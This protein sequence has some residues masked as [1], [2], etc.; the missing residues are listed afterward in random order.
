MGTVEVDC[1]ANSADTGI[2]M[3]WRADEPA[4][5]Q[6]LSSTTI[7]MTDARSTA[8]LTLPPGATVTRAFLYWGA[9]R[10]SSVA[11]L[12]AT[13]QRPGVDQAPINV[14]AIQ[15][16]VPT[17]SVYQSVA[18][19]TT[20]VQERGSGPYRVGGVD[21]FP[22]SGVNSDTAYAGWWMAVF[23]EKI[24]EP[25]RNLALFDGLDIVAAPSAGNPTPTV[26][27]TLS[28]F[29]VPPAASF[30][31]LGVIAYEGDGAIAQDSFRFNGVQISDAL[32][33]ADNFFNGTRSYLGMPVSVPGDLPQLTGGPLS[34]SSIDMDVID[35]TAHLAPLQTSAVIEA[36]G[37]GDVIYLAGYTT[38]IVT[39][40]PD[41]TTS[42]K[43]VQDLNG[44]GLLPG[45]ILE[46]TVAIENSGDDASI[47]TVLTDAL[48]PGVTYVPGSLAITSG[49]NAGA[50]TDAAGDDQGDYAAGTRTLTVRLGT[51][52]GA[53]AGG[54][55]PVGA[56]STVTFRVTVDAGT[57]G[58]IE[59]QAVISAGGQQG[60]P[61]TN[62][63]T[64]GNGP[65]G[66]HPPTTVVVDLCSTDAQCAAP[67]P[68][69]NTAPTPNECVA[70]VTDLH[71]PPTAPT[72]EA[73]THTC[74][75][76]P[77]GAE[78][79]DGL[80]NDCDGEVDDG[81]S[82]VDTD[83]DGLGDDLE[84]TIGTDPN[85][86]DSD[87]DGVPDGQ[88]PG[89]D[90]DSDGDGLI[91]AL[92][93]D[94]DN[95]GL[96][97]GTEMGL[98][99]ANP[100]TDAGAMSCVADGDQ[101][102]TLTDPLD[103]DTDDGGVEDGDEDRDHDGV[104]DADET[105]PTAGNGADDVLNDDADGDGLSGI[106]ELS[107]G[108]DPNDADSDDDGVPDGLE[109]GLGEDTDNDGLIGA[110]DPDSDNDG[111][112][113]GTEMG[114]DC[115]NPDTDPSVMSCIADA[116]GGATTTDPL[117]PDT[118]GGSVSDGDEDANHDG[119]VNDGERD[120]NDP[121]D[122]VTPEIPCTQDSACGGPNSGIVCDTASGNCGPG[123][124]GA[125]GNGCPEGQECSSSDAT[126]GT[127]R[128][129]VPGVEE[130]DGMYPEGNGLLC[131]ARPGPAGGGGGALVVAMAGL[132][133]LALRRRRREP[134]A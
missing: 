123:C 63:P 19:I 53:T 38:S 3:V 22:L 14:T 112:F 96:F 116:D 49:A 36:Q 100:A 86:A 18:D 62:T 72:C 127:C 5:G 78:V 131:A 11:D 21:I 59:N 13:I 42:T 71:C 109:P 110:L 85:D 120:P 58:S 91:G 15:S 20:I 54:V 50:K 83:G 73:A 28:G 95:D 129:P 25:L 61:V 134:R 51:G 126:A 60:A 102:A 27:T 6:A 45:D 79:C 48:P 7:A 122:D 97:D 80:D 47:N 12:T 23:Y 115:T 88:E 128:T 111:L 34:M 32:N 16:F 66:G 68:H 74:I 94:S 84:L 64:D 40:A 119:Q 117:D 118:D 37:A 39:F 76:V 31:K 2:D 70:C 114:L 104:V 103:A 113:D 133:G 10:A 56:T 92:D 87:D 69:C 65:G 35:V 93:P 106:V 8:V 121:S 24:D 26:T 55:M 1:G 4:A 98:D 67:T 17:Y 124:R 82:C 108:T 43:T 81:L 101:G 30:A 99:C 33:P 57:S 107:I 75:C 44:G 52:A 90:E 29:L 77:S 41:F 46:Y 9:R 89:L 105:D 132:A 125:D 130:P